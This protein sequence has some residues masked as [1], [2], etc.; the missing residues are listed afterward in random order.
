[1][2]RP[3]GESIP[4]EI[5]FTDRDGRTFGGAEAIVRALLVRPIWWW[6]LWPWFVP[7]VR[8]LAAAVYRCVAANRYRWFGGEGPEET[9]PVHRARRGR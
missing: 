3:D 6:V 7:G 4:D 5:R 2:D 8:P 9:C 1:V